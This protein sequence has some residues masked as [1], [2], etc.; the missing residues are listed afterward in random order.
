MELYTYIKL[1][2]VNMAKYEN[3]SDFYSELFQQKDTDENIMKAFQKDIDEINYKINSTSN[4]LELK[5]IR[6]LL[7][8]ALTKHK[9]FYRNRTKIMIEQEDIL[10]EV[11][12]KIGIKIDN[13][14]N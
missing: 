3:I 5:E 2:G 10:S 8:D 1:K 4:P 6:N 12:E 11:I 7:I 14:Q 13:L 9:N